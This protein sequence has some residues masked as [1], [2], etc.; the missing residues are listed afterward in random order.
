VSTPKCALFFESS[1]KKFILS[2]FGKTVD[3]EKF[4]VEQT[5]ANQ[6]VLTPT[7]EEIRLSQFAGIRKGSEIYIK[8]DIASLIEASEHLP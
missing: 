2:A 5:D 4:I 3:Q 6:R 7:G 1:A 8:S